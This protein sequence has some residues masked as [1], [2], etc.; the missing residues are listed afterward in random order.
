[1]KKYRKREKPFDIK[2]G[3]TKTSDE[4]SSV[5]DR[6]PEDE[7]YLVQ[8]ALKLFSV[9]PHA[10]CSWLR[11]GLVKSWLDIQNLS[12]FCYA[13]LNPDQDLLEIED[14]LPKEI[15]IGEEEELDLYKF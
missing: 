5:E 1:M 11:T 13:H 10:G 12:N 8:L 6:F 14:D 9:T 3:E 7:D 4:W 2:V 15:V